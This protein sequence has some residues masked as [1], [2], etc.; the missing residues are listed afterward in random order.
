MSEDVEVGVYE[1]RKI[2]FN[3]LA[4]TFRLGKKRGSG[5]LKERFS[6]YRDAEE[7]VAD[8]IEKAKEAK[9]VFKPI[10]CV[11]VMKKTDEVYQASFKGVDCSGSRWG[12][13]RLQFVG[14][15]GTKLAQEDIS[16]VFRSGER[17]LAEKWAS[18]ARKVRR[19]VDEVKDLGVKVPHITLS[20]NK[21]LDRKQLVTEEAVGGL[22][23]GHK[24]EAAKS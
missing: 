1:G 9:Y 13:A 10:S 8:E 23:L 16:R 12:A 20:H 18:A 19:L 21:S 14:L 22:N 6:T 17:H 3:N 4:R 24:A 15:A 5:I 11:V 2:Y 7:Y